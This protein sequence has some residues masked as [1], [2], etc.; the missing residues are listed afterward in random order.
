VGQLVEDEVGV[1]LLA[2]DDLVVTG[3][4]PPVVPA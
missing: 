2:D 3:V 1:E 4:E